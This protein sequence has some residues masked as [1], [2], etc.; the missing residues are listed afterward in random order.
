MRFLRAHGSLFEL[1]V[2]CV[3]HYAS[4]VSVAFASSCAVDG[5]PFCTCA[6]TSFLSKTPFLTLRV[7]L[8]PLPDIT[9]TFSRWSRAKLGHLLLLLCPFI[10]SRGLPERSFCFVEIL[11][12]APFSNGFQK[13]AGPKRTGSIRK[14]SEATKSQVNSCGK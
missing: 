10:T 7:F 4:A 1:C 8:A 13:G 12:L 2:R 9:W 3:I 14:G 6:R 5:I 11:T